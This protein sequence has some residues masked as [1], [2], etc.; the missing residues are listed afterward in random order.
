MTKGESSLQDQKSD[1]ERIYREIRTVLENAR[2][3]AY[4][5]VN[6]AMVHAY[7]EIGKIIT[8][9]EQKGKNRAEYGERII[10]KLSEKL[11]SEYGTGFTDRNLRNMRAF[12]IDF[13]NWHAV[14]AELSWTH[15]R[16]LV[17]VENKTPSGVELTYT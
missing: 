9:E 1:T 7:W 4:T 17:A 13:P 14:R 3:Y 8:E 15:Y 5:A 10:L 16:L 6:S 11:R 2:T 12:Y